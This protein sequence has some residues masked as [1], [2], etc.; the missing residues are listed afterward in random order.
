MVS[1]HSLYVPYY[2]NGIIGLNNLLAVVDNMALSN[3]SPSSYL[4]RIQWRENVFQWL[5]ERSQYNDFDLDSCLKKLEGDPL[6]RE[7]VLAAFWGAYLA[8]EV[9]PALTDLQL[10]RVKKLLDYG[11]LRSLRMEDRKSSAFVKLHLAG[12]LAICL[13]GPGQPIIETPSAV[14][15]LEKALVAYRLAEP[16]AVDIDDPSSWGKQLYEDDLFG[17]SSILVGEIARVELSLIRVEQR[18]YEEALSLVTEGAWGMCATT[19]KGKVKYLPEPKRFRQE[20][21][22]FTPYLP[23]SGHE[24]DI[25]E[26]ANIF[27]EV[28]RHAKDIKNWEDIKLYCEVLQYLGYRELYDFLDSVVDATGEEFGAAEY[29]G[30]AITFAE[31]QMRIVASPFPIV[32]KDAIERAETKERLKRDFLRIIWGE[33]TEEAQKILVDAEIEWMHNRLD[34]MVKEIRPLLEVILPV[35]FPFLESTIEQRDGHLI[36][37]R[38]RHELLTNPVVQASIEGLKIDIHDK[39]WVKDE[40]PKFLWRVIDTRNY[41]EKE[42]HLPSKKSG[43]NLEMTE[44]AVSIHSELLGIGCEGLLPQLLKIKQAAGSKK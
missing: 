27:E 5:R 23:H 10:E 24:F 25:Q 19:L 20:Y 41:F 13:I 42:Q 38:M 36:L 9:P 3:D 21:P 1:Q 37:T 18:N 6:L 40:L 14:D 35:V 12:L 15:A 22:G 31:D 2:R 30:K 7:A 33:L 17:F 29:W 26:A 28:K 16:P 32:T 44:R 4:C 11:S 8:N 43:K 34:N 39:E